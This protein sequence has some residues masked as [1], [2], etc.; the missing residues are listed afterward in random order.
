[1]PGTLF[2]KLICARIAQSNRVQKMKKIMRTRKARNREY[3]FTLVLTG[4]TDLTPEVQ[5][6]L[7]EAGCD[8][9]TLSMRCGRPFL[10]FTRRAATLKKA[11]FSAI[12]E[13]RKANIGA[14]VL[15]VDVC[16][17]VTQAEI[18]K[19]IRR[20]RQQVHQYVNGDRGPGGFPPPACNV[21][22]GADS[23][24]WH[25]CEVAD[26]LH[27]NNM[28]TGEALQDAKIVALI[29]DVLEL[30]Y[31][32]KLDPGLTKEVSDEINSGSG[33]LVKSSF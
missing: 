26:W 14:D 12:S 6:A 5:D 30:N 20:S 15:R 19:R 32:R 31:Q 4:I 3:D 10:T 17:L 1:M 23:L 28:I 8:D 21:S 27:Q 7:F 9:A 11:I 24:L 13:V 25:W 16:N 29:N 2:A 22:D 18:A 33:V